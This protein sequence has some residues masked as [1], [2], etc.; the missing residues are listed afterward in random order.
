MKNITTKYMIKIN[1]VE[2]EQR[3]TTIIL[4]IFFAMAITH[5]CKVPAESGP[6]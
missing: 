1:F 2:D 6:A 4:T 5:S 3:D